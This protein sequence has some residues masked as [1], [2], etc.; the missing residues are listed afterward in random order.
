M[1]DALLIACVL[2]LFTLV[3]ADLGLTGQLFQVSGESGVNNIKL[4]WGP[5]ASSSYHVKRGTSSGSYKQIANVTGDTYDDYGLDV[6]TTYYYMIATPD[7]QSNEVSATPF[8]PK[9][10]YE[11]Y[12]NTKSSDLVI[13]SKIQDPDGLYYRYIYNEA[14]G[15]FAITRETSQDGY[16]FTGNAT[17]LNSTTVC[18]AINAS[19]HLERTAFAQH[20][21]TGSVVMW[22]H[23]ENT[24]NYNL[25]QVAAA[26]APSPG[27]PFTFDGTYRPLGHDSR[28]LT[29][30]ADDAS[31]NYT[32]YIL[33]STNTNTDMNIYRLTQNWTY[34]ESL[35]ATVLQAQYREAPAMIKRPDT[36]LYY[37]FTSRASGWYPSTPNYVYSSSISEGWSEPIVIGNVATFATQSGGINLLGSDAN[38][39]TQYE[40]Q[41]DRWSGNWEPSAP[42]DRQ[43]F[44]PISFSTASGSNT[45]AAHHHFYRQVAYSDADTLPAD[46][47]A[48]GIQT[49]RLL[50]LG[51]PAST[52]PSEGSSNITLINDG[53]EDNQAEYFAPAS[54]PFTLEFDL[55]G[56]HTISAVDVTV[57]MVQGSETYYQ[58]NITGSEVESGEFTLLADE[59]NNTD[60]GFVSSAVSDGGKYRY[61]R[62]TIDKVINTHNGNEA[63]GFAGVHEIS[64]YGS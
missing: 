47:R 11:T 18:A 5:V 23:L 50:S 29:F 6:G 48:Y 54:V 13:K 46:Q 41:S 59:K 25:A 33:S 53:T 32:A 43:L 15:E 39:T 62:V 24:E 35:A 21:T 10:D 27:E 56:D 30:F 60:V 49:G 51:K 20:P 64:I 38:S 58:Y 57:R 40:M 1:S 22:A 19:C 12:D 3:S 34:V 61:V 45:A 63:D 31:T 14:N 28:D 4:S 7:A 8:A 26:H 55:C 36:G 37:L 52:S 9:G 2:R 16:T 44:L 42:P 17:V